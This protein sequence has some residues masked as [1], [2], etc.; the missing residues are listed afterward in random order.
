MLKCRSQICKNNR[1]MRVTT[2][3]KLQLKSYVKELRTDCWIGK[4]IQD[5][6]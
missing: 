4:E 2:E 3:L 6:L 1:Q 5:D